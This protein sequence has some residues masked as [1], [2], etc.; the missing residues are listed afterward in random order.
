MLKVVAAGAAALFVTASPL[1]YAQT[2]SAAAPA[3]LSIAASN[4]LT[5]QNRCVGF[6]SVWKKMSARLYSKHVVA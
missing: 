5:D 1:A 3:Q 2:P 4:T 6:R